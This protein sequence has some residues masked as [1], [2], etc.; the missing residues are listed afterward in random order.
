MLAAGEELAEA[1]SNALCQMIE[2]EN[3]TQCE[4]SKIAIHYQD[5]C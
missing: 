1:A 2:F 5:N 3:I 4:S